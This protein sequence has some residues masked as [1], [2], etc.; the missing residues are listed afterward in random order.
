MAGN[1]WRVPDEASLVG[2]NDSDEWQT[3]S[4]MPA[5][6]SAWE[7]QGAEYFYTNYY[8]FNIQPAGVN[9]G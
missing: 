4:E 9:S 5:A 8:F 3:P 7:I 1:R 2:S 6:A